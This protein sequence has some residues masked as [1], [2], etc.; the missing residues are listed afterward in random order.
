[1]QKIAIEG[2]DTDYDAKMMF[3]TLTRKPI[4]PPKPLS[5][6]QK[7]S[8]E[9]GLIIDS[10]TKV[11]LLNRLV[12][13]KEKYQNAEKDIKMK[14]NELEGLSKLYQT[15]VENPALGSSFDVYDSLLTSQRHLI[16]TKLIINQPLSVIK[17]VQ[18]YFQ[19]KQKVI[20]LD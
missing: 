9:F 6:D 5:F 19:S 2:I 11:Y 13:A 20:W 10:R 18:R 3:K 8:N 17:E 7:D 4:D 12:K 16:L 14:N 1:M 15:Y